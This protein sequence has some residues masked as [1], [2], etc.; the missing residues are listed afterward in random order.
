MRSRL[1]AAALQA[2]PHDSQANKMLRAWLAWSFLAA[3][4]SVADAFARPSLLDSVLPSVLALLESP[5]EYSPLRPVALSGEIDF[6]DSDLIEQVK[7]LAVSL[8]SLAEPLVVSDLR[9]ENRK[10]LELIIRRIETIDSR[11][12]A[13]ARKGLQVE[14][15]H[16]KNLLT[17]LKHSLTYQLMS[18]R[19]EK[20]AFGL[21]EEE[22]KAIKRKEAASGNEAKRQKLER[23]DD[24]AAGR[25]QSTL[26]FFR[27]AAVKQ[28]ALARPRQEEAVDVDSEQDV[29]DELLRV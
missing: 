27:K 13:D 5:P 9:I 16:A 3:D 12:R 14:R 10:T 18:A 8:T 26:D 21:S 28:A 17:G 7:L 15:L 24:E 1:Q 29:A 11:L 25:K 2:I 20:S 4:S 6:S 23:E 19:G 22:E